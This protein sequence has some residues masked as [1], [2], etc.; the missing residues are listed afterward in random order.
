MPAGRE[1]LVSVGS[2]FGE[3][4]LCS[5]EQ[6]QLSMLCKSHLHHTA[7]A[8][9]PP[10]EWVRHSQPSSWACRRLF[11]GDAPPALLPSS[12]PVTMNNAARTQYMSPAYPYDGRVRPGSLLGLGTL[13]VVE[14]RVVEAQV[15]KP[16]CMIGAWAHAIISGS[17]DPSFW[18]CTSTTTWLVERRRTLSRHSCSFQS[19]VPSSSSCPTSC[20]RDGGWEVHA[21]IQ[22]GALLTVRSL[23]CA[24]W[25]SARRCCI[26]CV[27]AEAAI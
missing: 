18:W 13:L 21:R 5:Q 3:G 20:T 15:Q 16:T 7:V 22:Q 25:P 11:S 6:L 19:T 2:G 4:A 9:G 10:A 1:A 14:H 23:K 8:Q 17:K 12:C 26:S 27:A 24:D